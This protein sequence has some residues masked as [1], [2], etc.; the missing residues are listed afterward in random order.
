MKR[1][2]TVLT[3]IALTFALSFSA[4]FA[5]DD[6][7]L[8]SQNYLKTIAL[9]SPDAVIAYEATGMEADYKADAL[10]NNFKGTDY[11]TA[12][13]GD[14]AKSII[15]ISL[16]GE[17]PKDFNKTNL[18]EILENRVQEDGTLTN[19]VN[20]GCGATIW[21]LMALETVNSPKVKAVA[22]K[23]STMAMDNGAYW[24]E[25]KGPNADLDTTGWAMEALSVAGRSTYDAAI[26]KA[27]TFVQSKLNSTDG[28]YDI[29]WGGNA[30]TQSCVLE[31]LSVAGY[32]LDTNAYNY[33]LS[34]Q[35]EDGT[36]NALN[37][38]TFKLEPNA[39][40]SVEGARALGVI[41]NG[42]FVLKARR[43]YT[44]TTTPVV[45][46]PETP[47]TPTEPTK[48]STTTTPSTTT[49]AVKPETT[50]TT[51][52]KKET[53]KVVNTGDNTNVMAYVV[54]AIAAVGVIVLVIKSKKK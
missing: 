12:S 26:S 19:D 28:S 2:F 52:P 18:V 10:L 24:Y 17:N 51:E 27:Y 8:K 23:L 40:A 5:N 31:G 54:A 1:I 32:T 44:N 48:P 50:T 7:F 9:D 53:V 29:G 3:S 15:A 47:T 35:N 33:L 37:Y 46:E 43:D 45:T 36:F 22:D 30:D 13:Y 20:G 14:L 41:N 42:S 11:V 39:Y 25:Y 16:L 6:A 38:N 21:T 34:Y 49:P 4:A